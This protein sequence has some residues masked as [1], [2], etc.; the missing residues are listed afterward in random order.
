MFSTYD[1]IINSVRS[2]NLNFAH[3]ETPFSIYLTIRKSQVKNYHHHEQGLHPCSSEVSA[4]SIGRQN[5]E[6]VKE[7][8]FKESIRELQGKL[9]ASE[10]RAKVSEEKVASAE[11][12]VLKA[13]DQIGK[14]KE[15]L[16]KKDD[17]IK[18]LKNVI[19]NKNKEI[20]KLEAEK[21]DLGKVTKMKEKEVNDKEKS[22]LAH[23]NSMKA[24]KEEV[25]KLKN[26]KNALNKKI[27][28]LEKDAKSG[29]PEIINDSNQNIPPDL[30]L[31]STP[32]IGS[33][34]P[35][36]ST[37]PS[38]STHAPPGSPPWT[39]LVERT[40]SGT[41][42]SPHTP[43][44]LPPPFSPSKSD[45][46][47]ALSCYFVNAAPELL[48]DSSTAEPFV[49]TEYIKNISKFSLVPRQRR[50]DNSNN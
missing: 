6:L 29:K 18:S 9:D 20:S 15:Y 27:K 31:A 19:K 37:Q 14:S 45:P 3:Y 1:Q 5:E 46:S 11:A 2:S 49:T 22:V 40:L 39:P 8:S 13:Y 25:K 28:Q 36:S 47:P 50:K 41:P 35:T 33:P 4:S 12:E 44:G 32:Q 43:P 38:S 34:T 23:Q 21:S 48:E 10:E 7:T 24:L 17:E 30:S 16:S 42:P 26:D